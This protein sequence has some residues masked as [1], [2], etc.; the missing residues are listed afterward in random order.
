MVLVKEGQNVMGLT[1]S[2]PLFLPHSLVPVSNRP[3]PSIPYPPHTSMPADTLCVLGCGT[4]GIAI[5]SGLLEARAGGTPGLPT[6]I[7]GCV[8]QDASAARLRSLFATGDGTSAV[9]VVV[10]DNALAVGQSDIVIL[11]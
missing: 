11:G 3:L 9:E 5:L 8:K 10:R 7:I 2:I 6:R 4:M 1:W